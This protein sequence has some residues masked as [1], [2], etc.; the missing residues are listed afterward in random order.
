MGLVQE[1]V[2]ASRGGLYLSLL[3]RPLL[4]WFGGAD[5]EIGVEI[6]GRCWSG[7]ILLL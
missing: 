3:D 5:H 1:D 2:A 7:I 6:Y 4:E